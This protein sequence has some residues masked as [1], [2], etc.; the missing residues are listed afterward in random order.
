[1]NKIVLESDYVIPNNSVLTNIEELLKTL[2]SGSRPKGGVKDIKTGIVSIGAEHLT[3][4]GDFKF[5]KIKFIPTEFYDS[6]TTGHIQKN[7]ILIVKDGATIGKISYIP[8]NFPYK[9]SAVNEHVYII[10]TFEDF[11]LSKFLFYFFRSPFAQQLIKTKITGSAQG[12]INTSFVKNFP[13]I[14]PPLNEQKRIVDKIEEFVLLVDSAKQ[15][16]EKIKILLKRYRQTLLNDL[17]EGT[18]NI[19]ELELD[20]NL[21]DRVSYGDVSNRI[22][23]G[24]TN[25]MPDSDEGAWKITAVNVRNGKINYDGARKTDWDSFRNLLSDKSRPAVGTVVI[26]KDGATIGRV[27]IID[28]ENTCISQSLGSLEPNDKIISEFLAYSLQRPKVRQYIEKYQRAV[29]MPHISITDL[30]KWE[31]LL[32]PK[33]HQEKIIIFLK[34]QLSKIEK[35][36]KHVELLYRQCNTI[37]NSILK[38]A[39]EGKLVP[40]YPNDEPAG[41]LLQKIKQEKQLIQKQKASRSKKNVK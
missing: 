36:E 15:A 14:L 19:K 12:G 40:Q 6:M 11:I 13:I 8:I 25:P 9:K 1:M 23:Y 2:E 21:W 22:T 18:F 3:Y 32:P 7:D 17:F 24:F 39:F 41:I 34:S 38:Q 5:K 4:N 37:K 28:K 20:V 27:G 35:N 29:A 16:I 10:R 33:N 30:A 31:L 26:I